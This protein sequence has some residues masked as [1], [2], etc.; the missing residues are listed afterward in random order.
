[1]YKR[2]KFFMILLISITITKSNKSSLT[3]E[4]AKEFVKKEQ[5]QNNFLSYLSDP[6]EDF[7]SILL[8]LQNQIG[9]I[10]KENSKSE[11]ISDAINELYPAN[12]TREEFKT[13]LINKLRSILYTI[14]RKLQN[15]EVIIEF[16]ER[17]SYLLDGYLKIYFN[18]VFSDISIFDY[19]GQE[20]NFLD[21]LNENDDK[22]NRD[23]RYFLADCVSK[24]DEYSLLAQNLVQGS[25]TKLYPYLNLYK[26]DKLSSFFEEYKDDSFGYTDKVNSMNTSFMMIESL[27]Y[28]NSANV[29]VEMKNYIHKIQDET[30]ITDL[31][32]LMNFDFLM[33]INL[34]M[35]STSSINNLLLMAGCLDDTLFISY[36]YRTLI[37]FR[38][39]YYKNYSKETENKTFDEYLDSQ[40]IIY[41]KEIKINFQRW[42]FYFKII[43]ILAL[44]NTNEADYSVKIP[45]LPNV[46]VDQ[47]INNEL[48][49][50]QNLD[51]VFINIAKIYDESVEDFAGA[52]KSL[53]NLDSVRIGDVQNMLRNHPV[54]DTKKVI[55]DVKN[56]LADTKQ[57]EVIEYKSLN[58]V[59]DNGLLSRSSKNDEGG[60]F[61]FGVFGLVFIMFL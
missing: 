10:K 33:L 38:L 54:F 40:P 57:A 45:T 42:Q 11:K 50:C 5:E 4:E 47:V 15:K 53:N 6:K 7:K 58:K 25:I 16:K 18:E 41:G 37:S 39:E 24:T 43:N 13:V 46:V 52:V 19:L 12:L 34:K 36:F 20:K 60:V 14:T 55:S 21:E 17:F 56:D 26:P 23:F 51:K 9:E 61:R 29:K 27:L 30:E 22:E 59:I 28:N 3:T 35:L 32:M 1:M 48:Q 31:I 49:Q 8:A 2:K 44:T